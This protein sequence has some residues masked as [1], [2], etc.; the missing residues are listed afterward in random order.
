MVLYQDG[1]SL[2]K[3]IDV[4][5]IIFATGFHIDRSTNNDAANAESKA[6]EYQL[7]II[8]INEFSSNEWRLV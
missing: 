5:V 2:P 7:D 3:N 8:G 6:S 4:D 1:L